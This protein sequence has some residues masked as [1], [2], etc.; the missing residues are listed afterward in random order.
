M[1]IGKGGI[2][3]VLAIL[4]LIN[5]L[6]DFIYDLSADE[7]SRILYCVQI[8]MKIVTKSFLTLLQYVIIYIVL[9]I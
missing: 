2:M 9:N 1:Q 6:F 8:C 7:S 4:L 3:Y 5:N